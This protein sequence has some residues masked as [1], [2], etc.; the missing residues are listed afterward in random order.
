MAEYID[1]EY[2][3]AKSADEKEE[4][5]IVSYKTN[6]GR[7]ARFTKKFKPSVAELFSKRTGHKY[8]QIQGEDS[9]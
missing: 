5:Y 6:G 7:Q 1:K 2:E 9:V 4:Y 3:E 8:E